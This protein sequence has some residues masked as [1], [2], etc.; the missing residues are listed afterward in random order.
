MLS[1]SAFPIAATQA[2]TDLGADPI[3][4]SDRTIAE[5]ACGVAAA[6]YVRKPPPL[7]KKGC[8]MPPMNDHYE[9]PTQSRE[10]GKASYDDPTHG[11]ELGSGRYEDPTKRR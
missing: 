11:R 8:R 7:A 10:I 5:S 2:Q 1:R 4:T 6:D 3:A 9:D